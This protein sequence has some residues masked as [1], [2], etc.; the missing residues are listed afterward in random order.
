MPE[1]EKSEKTEN[2]A[3]CLEKRPQGPCFYVVDK[4]SWSPRDRLRA[5]GFLETI[6]S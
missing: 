5:A 2:Q 4:P 1:E 3:V 6:K